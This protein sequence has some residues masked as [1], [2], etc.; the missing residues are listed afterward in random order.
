MSNADKI[1]HFAGRI[2]HL[3]FLAE[4]LCDDLNH[5]AEE[6]AHDGDLK[7]TLEQFE[8]DLSEA[9][10]ILRTLKLFARAAQLLA[11]RQGK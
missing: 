5:V 2:E 1:A 7:N 11:E 8:T 6:N 9:E 3:A 10:Q 4:Q